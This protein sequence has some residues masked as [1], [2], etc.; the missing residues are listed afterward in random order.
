MNI[1]YS[2]LYAITIVHAPAAAPTVQ[3]AA[4][5]MAVF[6]RDTFLLAPQVRDGNVL[7]EGHAILLCTVDDRPAQLKVEVPDKPEGYAIKLQANPASPDHWL[8]VIAGR[9]PSGALWGVRD[10]VHHVARI[11]GEP[12]YDGGRRPYRAVFGH[13]TVVVPNGLDARDWPRT[14]HRA[15]WTYGS[16]YNIDPP[17]VHEYVAL[18]PYRYVDN[19]SR[20]KGN[21]LLLWDNDRS[22]LSREPELIEYAHRRGVKVVLGVGFYSYYSEVEAPPHLKRTPANLDIPRW[23][24]WSTD[25]SLCPSHPANQEWMIAHTL[26]VL[27]RIRPDGLL[28][29]TG[30]VDYRPCECE[31][32]AEIPIDEL[33]V[34][35][36]QPI[37]DAV[38]GE[39]GDDF[40]IISNQFN[41]PAYHERFREMDERITFLW[42]RSCFPGSEG[43][44][45][46]PRSDPEEGRPVLRVRPGN[47]GYLVRLYMAGMGQAWLDRRRWAIGEWRKWCR[48]AVEEGASL[49]CSLYHTQYGAMREMFLP[50][51]FFEMVWNGERSDEEFAAML[52]SVRHCTTPDP[53]YVHLLSDPPAEVRTHEDGSTTLAKNLRGLDRPDVIE[54]FR[55][56]RGVSEA[57]I[58]QSEMMGDVLNPESDP[59][60]YTFHLDQDCPTAQLTIRGCLDDVGLEKD[61]VLEILLNGNSIGSHRPDWPVGQ[62]SGRAGFTNAADWTIDL[63][64]LPAGL[65][66][67]ELRLHAPDGWVFY[68]RMILRLQYSYSRSWSRH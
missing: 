15:S 18:N 32:C 52:E 12:A 2:D 67:F 6:F 33:F 30:E 17:R 27:R 66:Q 53:A 54:Q 58:L 20:W 47:S 16:D 51:L 49:L 28:F 48:V 61:Y 42:E 43:W 3:H 35:T 19:M 59:A 50:S 1:T 8:L 40:W 56:I 21:L 13:R 63:P 57:D 7:P 44:A 60:R 11:E 14:R 36:T 45:N 34:R 64:A 10:F 68:D 65:N 25:R 46:D 5:E 39:F 9:D 4:Q 37:L 41:R 31:A 22:V 29:Q 38:R 26:E 23:Q 55:G 24:V 62:S